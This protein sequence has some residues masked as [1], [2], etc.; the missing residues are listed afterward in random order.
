MNKTIIS[1]IAVGTLMLAA[2]GSDDNGGGSGVQGEAAQQALDAA[3]ELDLDLDES[4]VNDLA[5]QLSD[6][7]A[8]AIVDEGSDG[9][10]ELSAEGEAL[11]ESLLNCVSED[12]LID[13]FIEGLGDDVNT[14]DTDCL[15]EKLEEIDLAE[16]LDADGSSTELV[17]AV[18]ECTTG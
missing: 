14:I 17:T 6:E 9:D 2:C 1:A 15:R 11:T 7:D 5:N 12:A 16:A 8:Q 3:S 4:C 18:I 13:L 10:P